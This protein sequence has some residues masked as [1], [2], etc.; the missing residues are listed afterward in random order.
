MEAGVSSALREIALE[1]PEGCTLLDLWDRLED[2]FLSQVATDNALQENICAQLLHHIE[3]GS[4]RLITANSLEASAGLAAPYRISDLTR[5][6]DTIRLIASEALRDS[7]LGL[8]VERFST[9]SQITPLQRQVLERLGRARHKGELQNQLAHHFKTSANSFFNI[10]RHLE[11]HDLILR[12]SVVAQELANPK[13]TISTYILRLKTLCQRGCPPARGAASPAP[14]L[15]HGASGN[16]SAQAGAPSACTTYGDYFIS[17]AFERSLQD[18]CSKLA[19]VPEGV[20]LEA[21]FRE[22]EG[23]RGNEFQ[24]TWDRLRQAMLSRG[25]IEQ[26]DA[27]VKSRTKTCQKPHFRW[28]NSGDQAKAPKTS[29]P[30]PSV[31]FGQEEL[32]EVPLTQQMMDLI[33]RYG[34]EGVLSPTIF[35]QLGVSQGGNYKREVDLMATYGLLHEKQT[36]GSCNGYRLTHPEALALP[37]APPALA[38][39]GEGPSSAGPQPEFT[40]DVPRM[41]PQPLTFSD[42]SGPQ[43]PSNHAATSCSGNPGNEGQTSAAMAAV[44]AA[45]FAVAA[46]MQEPRAGVDRGSA[47]ALL[48]SDQPSGSGPG[49][50]VVV[51]AQAAGPPV[52][53]RTNVTGAALPAKPSVGGVAASEVRAATEAALPAEL[54]AGLRRGHDR[55]PCTRRT[56]WVEMAELLQARLDAEKFVLVS[57]LN[58]WLPK[59]KP[60]SRHR[61]EKKSVVRVTQLLLEAGQAHDYTV[62]FPASNDCSTMRCVKVL[63]HHTVYPPSPDLVSRMADAY[64]AW[65]SDIRTTLPATATQ[66]PPAA[67]CTTTLPATVMQPPPAASCT[68]SVSPTSTVAADKGLPA[69]PPL[70]ESPATPPAPAD[71]PPRLRRSGRVKRLRTAADLDELTAQT[72][73]DPP[74]SAAAVAANVYVPPVGQIMRSKMM[75]A[76]LLHKFL[77]QHVFRDT[78]PPPPLPAST[79]SGPLEIGANPLSAPPV[80]ETMPGAPGGSSSLNAPTALGASLTPDTATTMSP[81][82]VAA[83]SQAAGE[84]TPAPHYS[85]AHLCGGLDGVPDGVFSLRALRVAMP[86]TLFCQT[87]GVVPDKAPAGTQER[88]ERGER[89]QDLPLEEQV[90]VWGPRAHL[91]LSKLISLLAKLR[92]VAPFINM[93]HADQAFYVVHRCAFFE[94][95]TAADAADPSPAPA[96]P[97]DIPPNAPVP[98]ALVRRSFRLERLEDVEVYW[99]RLEAAFSGR[100]GDPGRAEAFPADRIPELLAVSVWTRPNNTQN[101]S[102]GS[103]ATSSGNTGKRDGASMKASERTCP[104]GDSRGGTGGALGE[105]EASRGRKVQRVEAGADDSGRATVT[106]KRKRI[107]KRAAGSTRSRRTG[108]KRGEVA[109]RLAPPPALA[110]KHA[111]RWTEEADAQLIRAYAEWQAGAW[112]AEQWSGLKGLTGAQ[113]RNRLSI[114]GQRTA[115]LALMQRVYSSVEA[116]RRQERDTFAEAAAQQS[117]A[118]QPSPTAQDPLAAHNL[119]AASDEERACRARLQLSAPD[120]GSAAAGAENLG[121]AVARHMEA[122]EAKCRE[123]E[124]E[125]REALAELMLL[126]PRPAARPSVEQPPEKGRLEPLDAGQNSNNEVD[127]LVVANVMNILRVALM[128]AAR[129]DHRLSPA[130]AAAIRRFSSEEICVAFNLLH[131]KG[132]VQRRSGPTQPGQGSFCLSAEYFDTCS[133]LEIGR[134]LCN[135]EPGLGHDVLMELQAVTAAAIDR[136][137]TTVPADPSSA[138]VAVML[139]LLATGRA[140]LLP[141]DEVMSNQTGGVGEQGAD[142]EARR[143]D[144]DTLLQ[145]EDKS[146]GVG[147]ELDVRLGLLDWHVGEVREKEGKAWGSASGAGEEDGADGG[148]P[149]Q[150]S[151]VTKVEVQA[152]SNASACLKYYSSPHAVGEAMEPVLLEQAIGLIH[153]G[154]RHGFTLEQVAAKLSVEE[155]V[156]AQ[157]MQALCSFGVCHLVHAYSSARYIS[158]ESCTRFILRGPMEDPSGERGSGGD[159]GEGFSEAVGGDDNGA[160][161]DHRQRWAVHHG[162]GQCGAVQRGTGQMGASEE[163]TGP[164]DVT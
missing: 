95:P 123:L 62:R 27:P 10:A 72:P 43:G 28:L 65:E 106:A 52:S 54:S 138:Q 140:H 34:P 14:S 61:M 68:T 60:G 50:E 98:A 32:L 75:R 87:L 16:A 111:P 56:N 153:G 109:Q 41:F 37:P 117:P 164:Q 151:A 161:D 113:C 42:A 76:R 104:A 88:C 114:L 154:R 2:D 137:P 162:R 5:G 18:L 115:R 24:K 160:V 77:W 158:A 142:P 17:D 82:T 122:K 22:Q 102:S 33:F 96:L 48:I 99:L 63:V 155:E 103:R 67:S 29:E 66:P 55:Y 36:V 91:Q 71:E 80:H 38:L 31:D 141:E 128:D 118:V 157:L 163:E 8:T 107:G 148:D 13:K 121:E 69:P 57:E 90:R 39:G 150:V 49:A 46:D 131:S 97:R 12:E 3:L 119:G 120:A 126:V 83:E 93:R 135:P 35:R 116:L 47:N 1:G 156:A 130:A 26:F 11:S 70:P 85:P 79:A 105:T 7:A 89:V 152:N 58:T 146:L 6:A 45:P 125:I 84:A 15:S 23:M 74:T 129:Q 108:R 19:A 94:E 133:S 149:V 86:L 73:S 92:L 143:C 64:K 134:S 25:L 59:V 53:G 147:L 51:H 112:G 124:A 139:M 101:C 81:Q 30:V 9:L 44:A 20:I 110:R 144:V 136:C 159:S 132:L 145:G 40:S 100:K 21:T 4:L 78:V 127:A